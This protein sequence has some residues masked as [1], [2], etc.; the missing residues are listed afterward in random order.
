[1]LFSTFIINQNT[2]CQNVE[3]S[4]NYNLNGTVIVAAICEDGIL[5][6]SDSRS[7]FL[8]NEQFSNQVYAYLNNDL[9]LYKIGNFIIGNSGLSMFNK[10]FVRDLVDDFNKINNNDSSVERTFD[11]Y[12]AF[13]RIDNNLSDSLIF[14]ESDF[15]IAGYE[16]SKPKIIAQGKKGRMYQGNIGNMIH[17]DIELKRCVKLD[18]K[19]KLTCQNLAPVMENAINYL[20][21]YKNDNKIGGPIEIIQIKPDNT[22][23][24]L[25]SFKPNNFRTY[26]EMAEAIID[27]KIEVKY[28]F[29]I[30]EEL[31]KK[32]LKEG[33]ELG[34]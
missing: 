21:E 19:I 31:L 14:A 3:K 32:T 12:L 6:A 22:H 16:N 5:F 29:P 4:K 10:K 17:S 8:L 30:S 11:K 7:S 33:I 9:K 2:Y 28:I 1:M 18:P 27:N 15:I 23:L 25:K 24:V 34:Y 20:A 13:L 26:K